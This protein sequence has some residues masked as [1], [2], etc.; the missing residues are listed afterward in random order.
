[1]DEKTNQ[2]SRRRFVS[3]AGSLVGGIAF[4]SVLG[5]KSLASSPPPEEL[6]LPKVVLGRTGGTRMTRHDSRPVLKRE[7][8][9][10]PDPAV[11]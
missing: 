1:M 7:I 3:G 11:R 5:T 4:S 9:V 8:Q 10:L 2:L 6:T